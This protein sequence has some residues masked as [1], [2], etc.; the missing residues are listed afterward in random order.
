[1]YADALAMGRE[2]NDLATQASA[3]TNLGM[4]RHAADRND[5]ARPMLAES[6]ELR[7]TL[8][9][10]SGRDDARQLGCHRGQRGR[11]NEAEPRY[12][13]ALAIFREIGGNR[14]VANALE[15]LAWCAR[16]REDP[17]SAA[18]LWGGAEGVRNRPGHPPRPADLAERREMQTW[19]REMLGASRARSIRRRAA[20]LT[21]EAIV[22]EILASLRGV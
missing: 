7:R 8:G 21:T 19:L 4:Q 3:L 16:H 6:L 10:R 12:R 13:E 2:F 11:L 20:S 22:D 17:E 14:L 1:M 18:R 9:D 15:G 5:E